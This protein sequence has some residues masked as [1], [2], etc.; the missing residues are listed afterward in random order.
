MGMINTQK[1]QDIGYFPTSGN[2]TRMNE[3]FN[4]YE[5][6]FNQFGFAIFF[7]SYISFDKTQ[8]NPT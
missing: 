8:S 1:R 5:V 4:L 2:I 7:F 3:R 6:L